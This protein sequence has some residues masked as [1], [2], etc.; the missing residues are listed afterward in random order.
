MPLRMLRALVL[1]VCLLMAGAGSAAADDTPIRDHDLVP[2][3]YFSIAGIG[4]FDVAPDGM[5]VAYVESRWDKG[6]D[7]R[8]P[9]LW[10]LSMGTQERERL[11]FDGDPIG[12]PH[13]SPDGR[14]IYF[15]SSKKRDDGKKAPFNGKSQVWR[16]SA[17]GGDVQPVT[18]VKDGV[19][20]YELS[21]DGRSLY[22]AT[23][24]KH[25]A[26]DPWKSLR[27]EFGDLEYGH[28]VV[29]YSQIWKLNLV[30][31]REEKVV[32]EE[33]VIGAFEVSPD[34]RFIAML[35][36]PTAELITNE[37]WSRADIFDTKSGEVTTLPDRKWRDEAPSPY[38]WM[39]GLTW[40]DDSRALAFRVDFDGYP[41]EVFVAEFDDDG[42]VGTQK[43]TRPDEV[44]VTGAMHW[45]PMTR[46]FCFTAD[47]HARTRV[48]CPAGCRWWDA[49]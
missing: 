18:R 13:W 9:E 4:P 23:K 20:G 35:T 43:L 29:K 24:K 8:V 27:E 22:Y 1:V 31:W 25:V 21:A 36:T 45:K 7:G 30:D 38:G 42:H 15:T 33:R 26:E 41:G 47:D 6:E 17:Q 32:D 10:V 39:L 3:D 46:D 40:A 48:L 12:S 11:T 19:H 44:Y 14:W 28:G 2:E 5:R 49:G 16:I 34:E 37:G